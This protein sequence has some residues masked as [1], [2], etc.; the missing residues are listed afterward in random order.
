MQGA[1]TDT[2]AAGACG[3]VKLRFTITFWRKESDFIA[4][5]V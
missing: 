3:L 1:A 4:K 5:A 2:S